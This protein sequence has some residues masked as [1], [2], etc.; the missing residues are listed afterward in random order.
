MIR[1]GQQPTEGCTRITASNNRPLP[2]AINKNAAT[3]R[4]CRDYAVCGT[5]PLSVA[6]FFI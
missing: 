1:Y 3:P 5:A 6:A 4:D 2:I